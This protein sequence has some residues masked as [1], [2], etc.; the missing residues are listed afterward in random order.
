M[1]GLLAWVA[2]RGRGSSLGNIVLVGS[3]GENESV[4]GE[5]GVGSFVGVFKGTRKFIGDGKGVEGNRGGREC[6]KG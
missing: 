5:K 3:K 1:K 6:L 4:K 2:E